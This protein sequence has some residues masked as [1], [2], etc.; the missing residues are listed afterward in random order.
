MLMSIDRNR[1]LTLQE[2]AREFKYTYNHLW[3]LVRDG[4]IKVLEIAPRSYLIDRRDLERYQREKPQRKPAKK[5][6]ERNTKKK[7]ESSAPK[8]PPKLPPS[9]FRK[10]AQKSEPGEGED[11]EPDDG[12]EYV[13]YQGEP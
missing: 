13:D 5:G 12:V 2:A 10:A 8:A 11:E 1:Y 7:T 3:R 6:P 4:A 9:I